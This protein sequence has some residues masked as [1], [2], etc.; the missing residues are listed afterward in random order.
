MK[1]SR[2]EFLSLAGYTF[3]FSSFPSIARSKTKNRILILVEL[4]GANDGLN[5]VIPLN[6]D[7]YYRLRPTIGIEKNRILN[8][9]KENGLHY[10]LKNIAKNYENGNVKIIQNLGY[11]HPVLSHFRSIDIWETG[12]DGKK[13]FRNGWL[14]DS[15]NKYSKKTGLDAK[16]MF[17][18]NSN[19]IFRGGLDGFIGP[20]AIGL[21]P[22]E[23]E[24]R[25]TV[26]PVDDRKNFGLLNEIL[27]KRK[28][29]S[30]LLKN[31]I[32]KFSGVK[33]RYSF[34]GGQLGSQL[35]N[36][37]NLIAS[38]I[39]IPVY[40]V[41]L[42]SFDTHNNQQNTHR[43]LLR[44]LDKSLSSTI[45][46]LKEIGVWNETL[47]MTYS[48]FGRRANENGSRGTDH[49]MAAPHFILG[50]SIKGGII[51]QYN[52]L[53][54]LWNNNINYKVDYRSL[55]EFVLRNHFNITDNPFSKFKNN[56]II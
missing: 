3:L 16:A 8:I 19:S 5:T 41:A 37:C 23:I 7:Y 32:S 50:G 43:R 38:N 9:S 56:L 47:I 36:V 20:N 45:N 55:Y 49:G 4:Q 39:Y 54:K 14:V 17:L 34:G 10:S 35:S 31:L 53:S 27:N 25:D 21:E 11:P 44:D 46:A 18:D 29:N 51:G 48:E 15:L 22:E 52:D 30:D 28:Q 1:N 6:Q 13:Q 42:G 24:V 12:G 2:R 33:N 40:K 26:V